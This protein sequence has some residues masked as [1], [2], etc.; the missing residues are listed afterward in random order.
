R[1]LR[2]SCKIRSMK[3]LLLI[4]ITTLALSTAS[5]AAHI[6]GGFFV[7]KYLGPGAAANSSRYQITLTVYM[8][9]TADPV[10]QINNLINFS[11]FDAGDNTF[12]QNVSVALTANYD[13][14]KVYDEPC[15]TGDQRGCYYK[16]I[17]YDLASVELPN[18]PEGYIVSYQRCCRIAGIV[19]LTN[20][21][22]VGNTFTTKIPGTASGYHTNSSPVF[23]IN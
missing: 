9:C 1:M 18:L 11:F 3:R 22:A 15:I 21:G 23:P 10:G 2:T 13:L 19:N 5:F 7:Y 14:G 12:I 4:L 17:V 16:I 6:K 8:I 20:S